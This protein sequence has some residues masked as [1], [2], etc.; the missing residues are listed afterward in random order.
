M[1]RKRKKPAQS[2]SYVMIVRRKR[3]T[4]RIPRTP[5]LDG[6]KHPLYKTLIQ[7]ERNKSSAWFTTPDG[8]Y[9]IL[10]LDLNIRMSYEAGPVWMWRVGQGHSRWLDDNG[11]EHHT[12]TT[13]HA[14]LSDLQAH[15]DGKPTADEQIKAIRATPAPEANNETTNNP[16]DM[17]HEEPPAIVEPEGKPSLFKRI[18]KG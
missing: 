4:R 9:D 7:K 12:F 13:L 2:P 5:R 16:G 1:T 18:R 17:L 10:G 11:A 3:R 6:R 15:L 14:C 8:A